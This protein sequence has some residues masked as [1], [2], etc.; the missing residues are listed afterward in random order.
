MASD[1]ASRMLTVLV[2]LFLAIL[3]TRMWQNHRI[4]LR[5]F[6]FSTVA[7][8]LWH[9]VLSV[10]K[11]TVRTSPIKKGKEA[12]YIAAFFFFLVRVVIRMVFDHATFF[13]FFVVSDCLLKRLVEF[14]NPA[15]DTSKMEGLATLLAIPE[16][17]SLVDRILTDHAL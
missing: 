1:L 2:F 10:C 6:K 9:L 12:L 13:F 8:I 3:A 11:L 16:S 5:L 4:V 15:L 17:T 14:L 7:L